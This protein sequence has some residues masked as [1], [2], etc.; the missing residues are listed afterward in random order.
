MFSW[1]LIKAGWMKLASLEGLV[2]S[3]VGFAISLSPS[4]VEVV[5]GESA[6][7]T[8]YVTRLYPWYNRRVSLRVQNL[9]PATTFALSVPGAV[10]DYSS[11]LTLSTTTGTPTG[12]YLVTVF[13]TDSFVTLRQSWSW[14]S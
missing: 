9:P 7:T 13:A 2:K 8:I 12:V 3:P 10:P 1:A 5:Q 11:T 6:T 14:K 4:T